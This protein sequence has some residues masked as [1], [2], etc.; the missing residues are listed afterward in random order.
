MTID[1]KEEM[2][3]LYKTYHTPQKLRQYYQKT[4]P[5]NKNL[6]KTSEVHLKMNQMFRIAFKKF[7]FLCKKYEKYGL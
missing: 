5:E 4:Y 1:M 7:L 2:L 6:F 3:R